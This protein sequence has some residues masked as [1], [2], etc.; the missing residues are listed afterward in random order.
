[1]AG[2]SKARLM[3]RFFLCR[4]SVLVGVSESTTSTPL[5]FIGRAARFG[6]ELRRLL[7]PKAESAIAL[8]VD[9]EAEIAAACGPLMVA[10]SRRSVAWSAAFI[11]RVVAVMVKNAEA[12]LRAHALG[13]T[14]IRL[15]VVFFTKTQEP[16]DGTIP[17]HACAH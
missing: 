15:N 14:A 7:A 3:F 8:L 5:R 6:L 11:D 9:H 1:M 16:A 17:A 2:D 13:Q 12:G 10:D 4:L